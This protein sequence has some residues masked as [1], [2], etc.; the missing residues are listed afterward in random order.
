MFALLLTCCLFAPAP[1]GASALAGDPVA[2]RAAAVAVSGEAELTPFEALAS[3]ESRVEEHVRRRWRA[4]ADRLAA[5]HR[6]FWMPTALAER[7]S[8]R[9]LADLPVERLVAQVDRTDRERV[10][11]FGN[12]Y[13]T[14]LWVAEVPEA[15]ARGERGLRAA[16]RELERATALK[17]GGVAAG[18]VVLALLCSWVDR[19]SRGYMTGRLRAIGLLGGAL[20][21]AV[22][23]VV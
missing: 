8:S 6:P 21:P 10:H 9:W 2:P 22:L 13:Q 7:A 3:A 1:Q 19:L 16:L 14:T 11:E 23:M 18:W 12:S 20:L 5:R 15:V 4:R 17:A